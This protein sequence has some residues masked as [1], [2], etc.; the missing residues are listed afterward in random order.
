MS[1]QEERPSEE[2]MRLWLYHLLTKKMRGLREE[3][4]NVTERK[5]LYR[6]ASFLGGNLAMVIRNHF[7]L[8]N[9]WD[10]SMSIMKNGVDVAPNHPDAISMRV[11]FGVW[12][13][14]RK[15]KQQGVRG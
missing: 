6:Y 4:E 8:W 15:E 3:I 1:K 10:D 5:C 2:E 12:E 14:L 11:I 9:Y 13:R 7:R